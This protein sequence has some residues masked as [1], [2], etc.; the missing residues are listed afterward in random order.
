MDPLKPPSGTILKIL[1]IAKNSVFH[2]MT[3]H[4]GVED[5]YIPNMK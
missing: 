5:P 2:F 3:A 1:M 4:I